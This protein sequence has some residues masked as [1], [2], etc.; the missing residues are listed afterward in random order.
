MEAGAE[1]GQW[2]GPDEMRGVR[3]SDEDDLVRLRFRVASL[4]WQLA[5]S[6]ANPTRPIATDEMMRLRDPVVEQELFALR[7]HIKMLETSTSWRI[8]APLRSVKRL[9]SRA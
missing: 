9:I 8:T 4:E 2:E 1:V 3:V 7:H 6:E 5:R